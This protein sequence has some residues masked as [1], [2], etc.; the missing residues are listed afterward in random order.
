MPR[1]YW[2]E[3]RPKCEGINRLCH[4]QAILSRREAKVWE[5]PCELKWPPSCIVRFMSPR[6]PLNLLVYICSV[7]CSVPPADISHRRND[8]ICNTFKPPKHDR[9]V[10]VYS[11][12]PHYVGTEIHRRCKRSS[13]IWNSLLTNAH[14]F[15]YLYH[16]AGGSLHL[17]WTD[18]LRFSK[19]P[20][21]VSVWYHTEIRT[22]SLFYV[23][24]FLKEKSQNTFFFQFYRILIMG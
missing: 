3:E 13:K 15:F 18:T 5:K 22:E 20:P 6:K 7:W 16:I 23:S 2:V 19:F 21:C 4:A 11:T 1:L 9:L 14:I 24:S 10:S 8:N 12:W 17:L